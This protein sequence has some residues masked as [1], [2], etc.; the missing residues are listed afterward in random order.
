MPNIPPN[1]PGRK[2]SLGPRFK[3]VRLPPGYEDTLREAVEQDMR[4]P[5]DTGTPEIPNQLKRFGGNS[6]G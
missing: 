5:E 2:M 4:D 1:N 6:N 3:G